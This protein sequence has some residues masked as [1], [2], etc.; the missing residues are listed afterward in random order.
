ML[1]PREETLFSRWT[2]DYRVGVFNLPVVREE[3]KH[4]FT[5]VLIIAVGFWDLGHAALGISSDNVLLILVALTAIPLASYMLILRRSFPVYVFT[6]V[7]ALGL[8]ASLSPLASLVAAT[9]VIAKGTYREAIYAMFFSA[10][11]VA[12]TTLRDASRPPGEAIFDT[13]NSETGE[14]T[15]ATV[16]FYLVIAIMGLA[17]TWIV[18]FVRRSQQPAS[19][20]VEHVR[21]VTEL[22]EDLSRRDEREVIAREI[23]DTVAHQLSHLSLQ[24]GM[25]E[26][27]TEDPEVSAAAQEMRRTVQRTL[28]EMRGLVASLRDSSS[29]GYTGVRERNLGALHQLIEHARESGAL[30]SANIEVDMESMPPEVVSRAAFRVTQ[31]SIS[32]AMKYSNGTPIFVR[33]FAERG[34]GIFIEVINQESPDRDERAAMLGTGA[35]LAGMKERAESLGGKF[36]YG[37]LDGFWRTTTRLPWSLDEPG[38][39]P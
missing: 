15:E 17:I 16:S 28:N 27:T 18:G 25:L 31:E 29:E 21:Q 9:W 2:P 3:L 36:S 33:V 26:T 24:T 1:P 7:T 39:T 37:S 34:S 5:Y 23:H 13:R 30:I 4:G 19:I 11:A 38:V 32:N 20:P 8:I 14:L 22:Q 35:G 12:V 6:I 10:V